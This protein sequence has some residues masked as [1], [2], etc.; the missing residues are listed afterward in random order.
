M[1]IDDR[2][3]DPWRRG[4]GGP[5]LAHARGRTVIR[6]FTTSYALRSV[7]PGRKLCSWHR[8]QFG[9][10]YCLSTSKASASRRNESASRKFGIFPANLSPIPNSSLMIVA[11][12]GTNSSNLRF[13]RTT[14]AVRNAK[15]VAENVA[16]IRQIICATNRVI[17][18]VPCLR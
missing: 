3:E 14:L 8:K 5:N 4:G 17:R 6:H 7:M 18:V 12:S 9:C 11:G 2:R 15:L 10:S 1:P 13:H 16:H